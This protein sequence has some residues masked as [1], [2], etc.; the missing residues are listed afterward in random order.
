MINS[1]LKYIF[2]TLAITIFLDLV[3]GKLHESLYFSDKSRKTD[4]LIHSILETKEEILIF[5]SSRALHHYNPYIFEEKLAMTCYNVGAGGQ[6]IFYHLALLEGTLER[7]KP[8]IAILDLMSFDFEMTSEQWDTD[9]LGILLPF[10]NHSKAAKNAVL[11]RGSV[12]KTK[13]FLSSI[14]P[15]NSKQIIILRNNFLSNSDHYNGF[16]PLKRVWDKP[17]EVELQSIAI[18]DPQKIDALKKF[19][20]ICITSNII[21]YVII[22]PQYSIINGKSRFNKVTEELYKNFDL[23][24]INFEND[25]FF[26]EHPEFFS[27]PSHLNISGADIYTSTITKIILNKMTVK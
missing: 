22:S 13:A 3:I 16:M 21:L 24:I 9:K 8:K 19:V 12:E 11:R 25:T 4:R 20:N 10:Y 26:L 5:G 7:Y 18:E 1:S 14:Y 6:N 27:D 2:L 23:E 15:F 17:P